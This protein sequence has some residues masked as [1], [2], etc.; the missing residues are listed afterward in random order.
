MSA[1][2]KRSLQKPI[3][4]PCYTQKKSVPLSKTEKVVQKI[5]TVV[6]SAVQKSEHESNGDYREVPNREPNYLTIDGVG[7][8]RQAWEIVLNA[9]AIA[10]AAGGPVATVATASVG[11]CLIA[12]LFTLALGATGVG[13]TYIALKWWLQDAKDTL[14]GD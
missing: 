1:M 3:H 2:V 5:S 11:V 10:Q 14:K 8:G 4:T 13:N 9:M 12:G 6:Q 7:G